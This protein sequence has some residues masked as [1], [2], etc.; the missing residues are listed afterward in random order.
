MTGFVFKDPWVLLFIPFVMAGTRF[1]LRRQKES[2][3]RYP[4]NELLSRLGLS[5]RQ[6]TRPFLLWARLL[7]I[8][9][10]FGALA[11][12]RKVIDETIYRAEG[13]DI[14]LAMDI[15][16][17]MA[18][19]DFELDRRRVNRLVMAKKVVNEFIS[20][21]SSDRVGLVAFAGL[22]YTVSPL[23]TD[24]EWLMKNLDRLEMGLIQD[25]TAIGS[26]VA[27]SLVRLKESDAK[28]KI[29]ILLTDGVNNAGE[30][31]PV[32]SA[33]AAGAL[34]VKV[35]TIG[36]GSKG[37]VPFPARDIFGREVYRKVRIDVDETVLREM[38]RSSGGQYF[39]AGDTESLRKVYREIDRLEKTEIEQVG[40]REYTE[41]FPFVLA[42]ALILLSVEVV[43]GESVLMRLP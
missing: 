21:R 10:F 23:T 14:M 15:S 36:I 16:G 41:L 4:S 25:G 2:G 13:I 42:L 32:E 20:A 30:I 38:A 27:A 1:Y 29:I 22:A 5:W 9:L 33:K 26:A 18:A 35:Y 34:G 11:G 17:S 8:V 24:Y 28:T 37:L 3:L 39:L 6:K 31:D 40:Y 19:E 43:L 12:P 7:V